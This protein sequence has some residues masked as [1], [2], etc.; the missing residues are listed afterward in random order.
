[1]WT[2]PEKNVQAETFQVTHPFHPLY[3][4][5]FELVTY[6]R[7]WGEDRVYYH[8]TAGTLC[9]LPAVWTSVAPVDPFVT[10]AAGRS[11]FRLLDLLE[12]ARLVTA[13]SGQEV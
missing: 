4:Q 8:D 2:T 11:T 6:H 7:N 1:M 10:V 13:L 12:L 9:S 5:V 3:G